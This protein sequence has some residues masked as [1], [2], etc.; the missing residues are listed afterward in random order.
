M[1]YRA[2]R[3][4]KKK[5]PKGRY[6]YLGIKYENSIL[7]TKECS[8]YKYIQAKNKPK[9][10]QDEIDREYP[11]AKIGWCEFLKCEIDDQ[12]KSCAI[13]LEY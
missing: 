6:C 9:E 13:K 1:K 10:F 4:I 12:C 5:I 2:P 7:Y 8:Y 3:K 11:E